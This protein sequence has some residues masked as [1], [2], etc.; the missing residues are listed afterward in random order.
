MSGETRRLAAFALLLGAL[1]F[2]AYVNALSN[3]FVVDDIPFIQ[4]NP[5]I[6]NLANL[7][8]M[9]TSGF[10]ESTSASS[11]TH[12][13]PLITLSYAVN[14]ALGGLSP[15]GYHLGNILL[16]WAN[17]VLV[18]LLVT[19][20][21][22]RATLAAC[23]AAVFAVHPVT[24]EAVAWGAARSELLAALF[25]LAALVLYVRSPGSGAIRASWAHVTGVILFGLALL[26]KEGAVALLGVLLLFE[27]TRK[28]KPQWGRFGVYLLT[29]VVYVAGLAAGFGGLRQSPIEYVFN[30]LIAEPL[31][32][33]FITAMALLAQAAQLWIYP[34]PLSADYSYEAIPIARSFLDARVILGSAVLLVSLWT[35]SWLARRSRV[36]FVGLSMVLSHVALLGVNAVR[37]VASL[38]AERFLYF[39]TAGLAIAAIVGLDALVRL[40]GARGRALGRVA[41]AAV[42]VLYAGRTWLRTSDWH[43]AMALFT[44]AAT[45]QPGSAFVQASLST[46]YFDVGDYEG[47]RRHARYAATVFPEYSR[48]WLNLGDVALALGAPKEARRHLSRAVELAPSSQGAHLSLGVAYARLGDFDR[49]EYHYRRA[50][51][52]SPRHPTALN[53]LANLLD[54]RGNRTE[55]TVL[56]Q[57]AL[58]IDPLF[59]EALYNLGRAYEQ[60]GREEE[61]RVLYRRFMETAPQRFAAQIALLRAK[62]SQ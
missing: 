27:A 16:H 33:R 51:E 18:M 47:A 13:R 2:V 9:F 45:V 49:A 10:W 4:Q 11:R 25:S 58:E 40:S 44:S 8:E 55:A 22:G 14:Y 59:P 5:V 17:A 26:C 19:A 41:V 35:L 29:A 39:P 34:V 3:G 57:R 48:A 38:F 56:W 30:P 23:G 50:V 36:A 1:I 54:R 53:N 60:A 61:A 46:A 42:I 31:G 37:P 12:Y 24:S 7:P 28:P 20:L 32:P 6:R 52:L 62:L 21:T 43:D 15:F